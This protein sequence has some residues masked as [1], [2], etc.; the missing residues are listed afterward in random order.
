MT[1]TPAAPARGMLHV[2]PAHPKFQHWRYLPGSDLAP[3]VEHFWIVEWDLPA[4]TSHVQSTLPHPSIHLVFEAGRAR[5]VGVCRGRFTRRLEGRSGVFGVKFRPGGFAPFFH[6]S[7]ATLTDQTFDAREVLGSDVDP[8]VADLFAA[9][10]HEEKA[11]IASAYLR[12]RQPVPHPDA[13]L[14]GDIVARIRSDRA[15]TSVAHLTSVVGSSVRQVQR[16]FSRYVGVSPKWV[17]ERSRI[18]EAIERAAG[19]ERVDWAKLAVELGYFDQPH[20]I[21]AFKKLVGQ[22]PAEYRGQATKVAARP[23]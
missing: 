16:L 12:G 9:T 3:F 2:D 15:I 18:H 17:I 21:R 22:S 8:T 6:G 1:L 19:G 11:A 7:V 20:F 13:T 4:G 10:T 5:I 14:A 23:S